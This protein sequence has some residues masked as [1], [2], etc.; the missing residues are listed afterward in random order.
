[1]AML[2]SEEAYAETAQRLCKKLGLDPAKTTNVSISFGQSFVKV[3]Y[4]GR[5]LL[6]PAEYNAIVD[7]MGDDDR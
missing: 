5:I 1:M 2:D 3:E 6:A 4:E 7:V